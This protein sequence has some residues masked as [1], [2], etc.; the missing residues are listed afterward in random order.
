LLSIVQSPVP[1]AATVATNTQA[2]ANEAPADPAVA[3]QR[4]YKAVCAILDNF[5]GGKSPS[6]TATWLR[7][8]AKR[9]DQLPI[10]NVDPSLVEWGGMVSTKM[11]QATGVGV[12]AQSQMNA[13]VAGVMDPTYATWDK[14]YSGDTTND[15]ANRVASENA[16]NQRRQAALEQKAQ[17]QEQ[18]L[19]ILNEIA[20]TRPKVRADMVAKYKVEF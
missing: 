12:V 8:G 1:A 3:S 19:G 20:E 2:G 18:A 10:L 16:R 11:K 4:Y 5:S 9:I 17:A 6:E 13:R 15:S 7:A 14:D